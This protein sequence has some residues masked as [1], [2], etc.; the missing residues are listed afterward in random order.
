MRQVVITVVVDL[1]PRFE[2]QREIIA[3]GVQE[4]FASVINNDI[5]FK[6]GLQGDAIISGVYAQTAALPQP[7]A[8][9]GDEWQGQQSLNSQFGGPGGR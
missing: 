5:I 8:L 4:A 9:F 1:L 2:G 7:K 3:K 6:A